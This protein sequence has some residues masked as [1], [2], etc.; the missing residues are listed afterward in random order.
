MLQT[1]HKKNKK[2]KKYYDRNYNYFSLN[3]GVKFDLDTFL[4]FVKFTIHNVEQKN[5]ITLRTHYCEQTCFLQEFTPVCL[6]LLSIFSVFHI[7]FE[8]KK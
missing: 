6:E 2:I 5:E 8:Y 3:F 1:L 4:N 7:L